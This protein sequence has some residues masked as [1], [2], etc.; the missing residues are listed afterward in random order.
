MWFGNQVYI[1]LIKHMHNRYNTILFNSIQFFI[2]P[3]FRNVFLQN[4]PED[5][6]SCIAH[7]SAE[8][9]LKSAVLEEKKF[10]NIESD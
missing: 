3:Q 2:S 10:K 4:N 8:N 6:W 5:H 9:M 7:Q 1:R